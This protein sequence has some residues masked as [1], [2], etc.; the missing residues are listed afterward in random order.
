MTNPCVQ[1]LVV[2]VDP[3]IYT[4]GKIVKNQTHTHTHK[5]KH[6]LGNLNEMNGL[7]ECQ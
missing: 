5:Y 1:F 2:V 4:W 7:N 3:Q 6:N